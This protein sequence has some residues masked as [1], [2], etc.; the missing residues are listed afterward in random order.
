MRNDNIHNKHSDAHAHTHTHDAQSK[1]EQTAGQVA[2]VRSP[3]LR[4]ALPAAGGSASEAVEA[5]VVLEDAQLPHVV[6]LA[7]E[8]VA[9]RAFL[10][11]KLRRADNTIDRQLRYQGEANPLATRKR[12]AFPVNIMRYALERR[13]T[14]I[15]TVPC[16]L[17]P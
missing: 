4:A 14:S 13:G 8:V 5:A 6:N 9:K 16:L 11:Q 2:A 7:L 10:H 1:C 12:A 15:F 17:A 3:L